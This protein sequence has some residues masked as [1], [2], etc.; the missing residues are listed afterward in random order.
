MLLFGIS[1]QKMPAVLNQTIPQ[2]HLYR[3]ITVAVS[4]QK[5]FSYLDQNGKP[6]GIDVEIIENFG[7]K[8]NLQIDYVPFNTSLNFQ[9]INEKNFRR[10]SKKNDLR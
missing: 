10:F 4:E 3:K 7:R 8:F 2:A 1:V 9:F 6:K 5:P